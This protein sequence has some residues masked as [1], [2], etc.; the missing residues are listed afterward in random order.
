[1]AERKGGVAKA[2]DIAGERRHLLVQGGASTPLSR[3]KY[4]SSADLLVRAAVPFRAEHVL[5]A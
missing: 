4:S 3:M 1:M 2:S 5:R